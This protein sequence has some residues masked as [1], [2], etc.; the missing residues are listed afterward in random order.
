MTE[1]VRNPHPDREA[2]ERRPTLALRHAAVR[3]GF[4]LSLVL[5]L[6]GETAIGG[7]WVGRCQRLLEEVDGDVVERGYVLIHVMF[8][9]IFAGEFEPA[10][11]LAVEIADYGRR[12]RDPD[13]VANGLNAQGRM[14]LYGG[15][16]PEGTF[17]ELRAHLDDEQILE[18]TYITC[19]YEM[20]AMMSRA[21][22]TEWDD[23]DDPVV[24]VPGPHDSLAPEV[25]VE[26]GR[27]ASGSTPDP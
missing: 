18:L 8:R 26:P 23:R 13:L 20:H 25:G 21:L 19:L 15:R 4:W 2:H 9:H 11:A 3:C 14:L 7:G 16:V 5:L 10:F 27:T 17:A 22:R 6:S 24:E 1:Q 12:F